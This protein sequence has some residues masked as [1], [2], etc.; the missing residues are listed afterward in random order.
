VEFGVHLSFIALS[1]YRVR[2]FTPTVEL[3]MAGHPTVGTAFVLTHEGMLQVDE[4]TD[5]VHSSAYGTDNRVCI[6]WA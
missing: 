3:P 4:R 6:R 5:L 2:F 1:D